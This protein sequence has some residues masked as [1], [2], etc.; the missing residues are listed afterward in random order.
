MTWLHCGRRIATVCVCLAGATLVSA[1]A[2]GAAPEAANNL[3]VNGDA[4]Q[5][6]ASPNGYDVVADIPG[7]ARKGGFT[8]V[9]YGAADFPGVQAGSAFGGGES[10]FAG[11][12]GNAGSSVSQQISIASKRSLIDSGKGK[13]TLSGY[14]GGYGGQDDSLA[15]T[16]I[17]L[18][19]SGKRLGGI[20]IG[21]VSAA[22][23]KLQTGMLKKTTTGLVPKKTRAIRIVLGADRTA[24]NYN[25]GY[26]DNLSLLIGR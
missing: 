19:Q 21:P 23:R 13:A 15:A 8:V 17:F 25:D 18:D 22:A 6:Q 3:I 11:G 9:S 12:P 14:L 24:G 20:K 1:V 16:A 10:F 7:W 2:A 26:A 5:G 4:E